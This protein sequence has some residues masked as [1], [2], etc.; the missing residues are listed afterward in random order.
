[1]QINVKSYGYELIESGGGCSGNS[2]YI[3]KYQ[4]VKDTNT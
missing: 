1:M 3:R 2:T 4:I